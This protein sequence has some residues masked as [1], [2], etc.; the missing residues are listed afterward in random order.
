MDQMNQME[1]DNII[2]EV[3]RNRSEMEADLIIKSTGEKIER[4]PLKWKSREN[5][6]DYLS[7][8][9][10]NAY[11]QCPACFYQQYMAEETAQVDNG[12]FFTEFGS[13]LHEVVEKACK[14]Y[15]TNGIIVNPI[16]IYDE[17]W[18]NHK[19]TDFNAYLEGKQ[20][21]TEH[22][23]RNPVDKAT[24]NTI[25]IEHEWRGELGGCTFGLMIDYVG[26]SKDDPTVGIL[27]DYK[28]NRLPF[29]NQE[30]EDSFQ[31]KVYEIVL[32]RYLMPEIKTW[33]SGYEMFRFGWQQCPPRTEQDLEDAEQ[34][35]ANIWHQISND[36]IWEE[37][38]NN[39]CGYRNCRFTCKT[40]ADFINNPNR[41]V[42]AYNINNVDYTEIDRQR[43]TLASYEKIAK[44]RK[45]ECAEILKVAV[46]KSIMEGK[47]L[48]IDGK[49]L[50]LCSRE[51]QSY[52]Y[53]DTRNILLANNELGL[54][55]NC[56]SI[57]KT[58]L[59]KAISDKPHLQ[60]QLANC[61]STSYATP[62]IVK[63]KIK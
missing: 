33:I 18:K 20:L 51:T 4:I 39:Y 17:V 37:K 12:N 43:E 6:L 47:K 34:Y 50:Q 45:D 40:Y 24:D 32:R 44:T 29:T 1:L 5:K 8:S 49:E 28:S 15:E 54:L 42:D 30:L 61:L 25:L 3:Y 27:K 19:L 22:F 26:I 38:L 53:H 2:L 55:D 7:V 21:I 46:Q 57:G 11:E 36:N 63:K 9:K 14:Y 56:L 60:M 48:I 52:K 23:K 58:K 13:I 62:Y 59:D 41:Y 31:L 16:Q 35:I 10:I